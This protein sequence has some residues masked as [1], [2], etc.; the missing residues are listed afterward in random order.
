MHA[1]NLLPDHKVGS[2]LV[3][4]S[5]CGRR[6][7]TR[8]GGIIRP[9]RASA[10]HANGLTAREGFVWKKLSKKAGVTHKQQ[11]TDAPE[12]LRG[13][14]LPVLRIGCFTLVG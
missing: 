5:A 12:A 11:V 4:A 14:I 10:V 1:T 3:Q 13:P 6:N 2:H 8:L 9:F 7:W